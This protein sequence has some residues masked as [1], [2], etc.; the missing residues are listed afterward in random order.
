MF[1]GTQKRRNFSKETALDS[2]LYYHR[3]LAGNTL[4]NSYSAVGLLKERA[5]NRALG[6]HITHIAT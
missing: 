3:N 5:L 1:T 6:Y 2:R 4:S